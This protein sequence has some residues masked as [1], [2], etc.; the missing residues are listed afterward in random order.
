MFWLRCASII[1]L[2]ALPVLIVIISTVFVR[3]VLRALVFM[4]AAVVLKAAHYLI[5][6]G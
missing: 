4:R 2:S 5:D 6:I 3:K 1:A